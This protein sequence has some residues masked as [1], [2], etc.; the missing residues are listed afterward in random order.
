MHGRQRS[1]RWL[2]ALRRAATVFWE[3]VRTTRDFE[4]FLDYLGNNGYQI[5]CEYAGDG[6]PETYFVLC[7]GRVVGVFGHENQCDANDAFLHE[8]L[9]KYR[10]PRTS[11]GHV[12]QAVP[13][14]VLDV[15]RD[16]VSS[17]RR[18]DMVLLLGMLVFGVM[19]DR[20]Y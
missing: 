15:T 7:G 1:R 17:R 12:R 10:V 13:P 19:Y 9:Q 3:E 2:T 18:A 14:N 20:C 5:C 11:R 8:A 6:G 16:V 4:H